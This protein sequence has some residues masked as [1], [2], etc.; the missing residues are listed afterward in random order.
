MPVMCFFALHTPAARYAPEMRVTTVIY[1]RV[2]SHVFI[3]RGFEYDQAYKVTICLVAQPRALVSATAI[4]FVADSKD[5]WSG[6]FS[7]E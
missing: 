3:Q 5:I 7:Q 4:A 6:E 1:I 2:E